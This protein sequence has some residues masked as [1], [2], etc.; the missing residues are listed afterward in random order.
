MYGPPQ[1]PHAPQSPQPAQPPKAPVPGGLVA[2]R[3]LFCALSLLS[4]GFLGWAPLLRLAI[5]TRKARDWAL[6][7]LALLGSAALFTYIVVTAEKESGDLEAFLGIGAIVLLSAGS[8]TYYLVAEIRHFDPLRTQPQH[9]P[10]GYAYGTAVTT[11]S[12]PVAQNPYAG[13]PPSG[14]FPG[15]ATPHAPRSAPRIDQVRAELD[16]LSELLRHTGEDD[17]RA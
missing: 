13:E 10:L 16:E 11:P 1:A 15:P 12:G 9:R 8:I 3:V 6:F 17:G 7:V 2:L 14:A 4:C 5:I